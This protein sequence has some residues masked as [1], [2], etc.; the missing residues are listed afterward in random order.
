M[1]REIVEALIRDVEK[2]EESI[3]SCSNKSRIYLVTHYKMV[4]QQLVGIVHNLGRSLGLMP[5]SSV[6]VSEDTKAVIESL[7]RDLQQ[8]HFDIKHSDER[9][10][11][12]LNEDSMYL[13]N[14]PDLQAGLLLDIARSVGIDGTS[15]T[16]L[17]LQVELLKNDLQGTTEAYDLQMMNMLGQMV[18][19]WVQNT[20]SIASSV[21]ESSHHYREKKRIEPLYEAFICPLTKKVMT[22]PVTLEN[23]QTYERTAIERWF[24]D[25]RENKRAPVCP[26]TGKILE[27]TSLKPS[28]ALR[29]TIEEWTIRN[30]TLRLENAKTVLTSRSSDQDVLSELLDIQVL[31]QKNSRNKHKTR[32]VGLIPL[33][34]DCLKGNEQIR[35]SAL[36][37]LCLLA[38]GVDENK[39]CS[40]YSRFLLFDFDVEFQHYFVVNDGNL[41]VL[42]I[43][44]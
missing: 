3:K 5:V 34:V 13:K 26:T 15:S 37:T 35:H 40:T 43:V 42:Y 28:I 36:A 29:H 25:C 19:N 18:D 21:E 44:M 8:S 38:D 41:V 14:D 9:I 30:E 31:C 10:C 22:D 17:K 32:N 16:A 20:D 7:S 39:V 24:R 11:E 6:H 12:L 2:A 4:A 27:S 1:M 33:I 23:G